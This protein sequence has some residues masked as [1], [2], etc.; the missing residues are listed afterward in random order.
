MNDT[1]AEIVAIT[2]GSYFA[3]ATNSVLKISSLIETRTQAAPADEVS[4]VVS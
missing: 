1:V 2:S 3:S 4:V